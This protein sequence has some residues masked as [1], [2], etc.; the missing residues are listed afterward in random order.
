MNNTYRMSKTWLNNFMSN[1]KKEQGWKLVTIERDVYLITKPDG[2]RYGIYER[3]SR[4]L[5]K[6]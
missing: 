5:I 3:P 6:G 4:K 1:D 2:T